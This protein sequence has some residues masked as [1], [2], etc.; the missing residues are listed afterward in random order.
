MPPMPPTTPTA[1][2]VAAELVIERL[3]RRIAAMTVDAEVTAIAYEAA[4]ARI[5]DLE[6]ALAA[7][8]GDAPK[9]P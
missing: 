7:A 3:S 8:D 2:T 5:A 4:A 9:V 1:P 6:Q